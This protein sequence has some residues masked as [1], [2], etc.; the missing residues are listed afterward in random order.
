MTVTAQKSGA[1][2]AP[3][4]AGRPPGNAKAAD[5]QPA[6]K[7]FPTGAPE[8]GIHIH[9]LERENK[10]TKVD[11]AH[12]HLFILEDGTI[13]A[14]EEDGVHSHKLFE[15]DTDHG[16]DY[17]GEHF[18]QVKLSDGTVIETEYQRSGHPH[19]VQVDATAFD[20]VHTHGLRLPGGM[21]V[22]SVRGGEF[23]DRAGRPDQAGNLSLPA[24]SDVARITQ[25]K[26][27]SIID[28]L[29]SFKLQSPV[30]VL[31][32]GNLFV[33]GA[34]ADTRKTIESAI[35]EMLPQD[36]GKT[37]MVLD[38]EP[39]GDFVEVADLIVQLRPAFVA[40]KRKRNPTTRASSS[41]MA[42]IVR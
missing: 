19:E 38:G 1:D 25:G 30:L 41:A 39:P 5:D 26:A 4:K 33:R 15:E 12:R 37:L 3:D 23:W 8:A 9:A 10:R 18:H 6:V 11:G 21:I 20:G 32:D 31:S 7:G 29:Q 14:T 22:E 17:D 24:A 2:K 36:I 13:L 35:G 28:K 40:K 42:S 27:G 34:D 16:T